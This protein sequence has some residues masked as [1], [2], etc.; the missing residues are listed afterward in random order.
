MWSKSYFSARLKS[1][2]ALDLFQRAGFDYALLLSSEHPDLLYSEIA[3]EADTFST[4]GLNDWM[5]SFNRLD[6]NETSL[7]T[8]HKESLLVHRDATSE[9]IPGEG[10]VLTVG[11]NE[12]YVEWNPETIAA[13]QFAMR[14][15]SAE[16][17]ELENRSSEAEGVDGSETPLRNIS[18]ISRSETPNSMEFFDALED[19]DEFYLYHDP[20]SDMDD[21]ATPHLP[22]FTLATDSRGSIS[23]LRKASFALRSNAMTAEDAD[24]DSVGFLGEQ[25]QSIAAK[26]T[27]DRFRP[28]KFV[29]ELSKLR[30]RFNKESRKRRLI[31]AEMD[32]TNAQ[33]SHKVSGGMKADATVGNL[34]LVDPSGE[35]GETLY[36]Q[37]LG[38]KTDGLSK[39]TSLWKMKYE[40]FTRGSED[41]IA[42]AS[43][44]MRAAKIDRENGRVDGVDSRVELAFSPMRFVY[45]QQLW[46]EM[47]DYFFEG[48]LGD[49]VWGRPTTSD[50]TK[51]VVDDT[52][53]L[54]VI[55][56]E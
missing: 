17:L 55:S 9:A 39:D 31:T 54:F 32:Q 22:F 1:L 14:L 20:Y 16:R 6:E 48:I 28:A 56:I 8:L 49:A 18:D 4:E 26:A 19:E 43:D 36:S 7:V 23:P 44:D 38:L 11:F 12:L 37:I 25:S 15:P 53:Q 21:P 10:S 52:K 40:S 41:D 35:D 33:Y 29:F 24:R 46:L 30:V 45:L 50:K 34:T 13:V 2:H 47:A 51:S 5:A 42:G 3:R 27:T